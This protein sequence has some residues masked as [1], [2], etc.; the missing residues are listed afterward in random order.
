MKFYKHIYCFIILLCIFCFIN[1]YIYILYLYYILYISIIYD[2]QREKKCLKIFRSDA[3][4]SYLYKTLF[5]YLHIY[6]YTYTYTYIYIHICK[7]MFYKHIYVCIYIY[8]KRWCPLVNLFDTP[9]QIHPKAW[10]TTQKSCWIWIWCTRLSSKIL[11]ENKNN[12]TWLVF[13]CCF[14]FGGK[15]QEKVASIDWK[16][17]IPAVITTLKNNTTYLKT[18]LH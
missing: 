11:K 10:I 17:T 15:I 12:A 6:T 13:L 5:T 16:R 4:F 1:I 3:F 2:S 18:E 7:Y 8:I 14:N 9:F